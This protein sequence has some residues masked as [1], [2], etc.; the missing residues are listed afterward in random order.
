MNTYSTVSCFR[1]VT[2][3]TTTTIPMAMPGSIGS[4]TY[5]T[6][7]CY[8][9]VTLVTATTIPMA[10]PVSIRDQYLHSILF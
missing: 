7:S 1:Y 6:V 10:M 9:Y 4:N 5:S 8:R 2:L 3:V